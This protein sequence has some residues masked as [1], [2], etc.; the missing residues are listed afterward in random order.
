MFAGKSIRLFCESALR[1]GAHVRAGEP[2]LEWRETPSG[3]E[4]VT[5]SK[6][7]RSTRLIVTVGSWTSALLPRL[8]TR[9]E[10]TRQ[11]LFW[12]W[13]ERTDAF[14]LGT[15]TCWAAQIDGHGGLFYGFPMLPARIGGQ[16]GL[17]IAHHLKG[18]P[19]VPGGMA[20]V[21]AAEFDVVRAALVSIFVDELGPVVATKT[22]MYTSTSDQHFIVDRYPDSERVTVACGFSGH[23]FKFASVIGEALADLAVD[24]STRLPIGFLGLDRF[25]GKRVGRG[26]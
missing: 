6:T 17:K 23:G 2:A 9:L 21:E 25:G 12:V 24:G 1:Y 14:E 8:P 26:A 13:P 5:A 20:P 4:V 16:L 10:V 11:A 3:I 22:C 7:H 18:P 19:T 15:F